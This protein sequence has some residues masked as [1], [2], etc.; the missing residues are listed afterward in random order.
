MIEKLNTKVCEMFDIP[1]KVVGGISCMGLI[2]TTDI[3]YPNLCKGDNLKHLIQII[4]KHKATHKVTYDGNTE[5]LLNKIL[6]MRLTSKTLGGIK[7]SVKE[8]EWEY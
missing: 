4:N 7:T 3:L 2:T 6:K 5:K 8:Y 1:R